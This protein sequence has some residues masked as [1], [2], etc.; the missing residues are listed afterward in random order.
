M[1]TL[2]LLFT[3]FIGIEASAQSV[4]FKLALKKNDLEKVK[5]YEAKEPGLIK[6]FNVDGEN[7]V[8]YYINNA[9]EIKQEALDYLTS[10]GIKPV[11]KVQENSYTFLHDVVDRNQPI[12]VEFLLKNGADI[13][14]ITNSKRT[15]LHFA[16]S[17]TGGGNDEVVKIL[18]KY[19]AN[20]NQV[21]E[22]FTPLERALFNRNDGMAVILLENGADITI[23][24]YGLLHQAAKYPNC[25]K[26]M[27]ALLKRGYPINK[28]NHLN[29]TAL[30]RAIESNN[31]PG[32]K[33]LLDNGIEVTKKARERAEKS[34]NNEIIDLLDKVK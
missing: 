25:T 33:V 28:R 15:P 4:L 34:D 21:D 23:E 11:F 2:I 5:A 16:A 7:I 14:A 10:F 3:M 24:D 19:K 31:A 30:E 1:K 17:R 12:A 32:V 8:N 20:I 13:H 18:L 22:D 9:R 26:S 6:N 29:E 27:Q